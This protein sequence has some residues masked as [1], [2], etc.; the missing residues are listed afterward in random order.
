MVLRLIIKR[1]PILKHRVTNHKQH[2]ICRHLRNPK[3]ALFSI[4]TFQ[5]MRKVRKI[6]SSLSDEV[7]TELTLAGV[8]SVICLV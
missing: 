4:A 5:R 7:N 8:K 1:Y 3:F 6:G 2:P